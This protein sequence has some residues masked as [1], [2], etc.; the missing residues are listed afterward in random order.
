MKYYIYILRCEDNSL[1]TGI[2]NN[3]EKRL[4]EH[5][6]K[7]KKCAKYT[8]THSVVKLETFWE[9][10]GKSLASKLEYHIK[11]LTKKEKEFLITTRDLSIVK[12]VEKDNY[13]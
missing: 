7:T 2:T 3:L 10:N 11:K 13:N 4:N 6:K 9:T 8:L 5:I 1:Y 12:N